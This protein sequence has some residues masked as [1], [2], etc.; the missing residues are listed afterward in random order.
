MGCMYA[1]G[2]LDKCQC[3]CGGVTHGLMV[4]KEVRVACSPAAASRCQ[5][6][7]EGKECHCACGG[8]NH[9]LYKFIP[10]FESIII[11]TYEPN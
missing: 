1:E 6:G 7:E 9:G 5:N 2:S 11:N 10:S 8:A 4:H 3:A